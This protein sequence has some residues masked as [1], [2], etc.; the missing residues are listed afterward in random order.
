MVQPC[1][2]S[3][4]TESSDRAD[5]V[6]SPWI[7]R[8][9]KRC[10]QPGQHEGQGEHIRKQ[11][12]APIDRGEEEQHPGENAAGEKNAGI[13]LERC[14]P[15]DSRNR[16]ELHGKGKRADRCAAAATTT[17]EPYVAG[18]RNEIVCCQG[19]PAALALRTREQKR[20]PLRN[21]YR[22]RAEKTAN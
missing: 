22:H 6:I 5:R 1:D 12:Y 14:G 3:K 16:G 10:C 17:F 11:L 2:D 19:M 18:D 15:G 21:A 8:K 7:E 13:C 4:D 9:E 20:T